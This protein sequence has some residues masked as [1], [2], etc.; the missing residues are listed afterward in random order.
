MMADVE[1][2]CRSSWLTM[3]ADLDGEWL[4]FKIKEVANDIHYNQI[5]W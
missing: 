4:L 5:K 1:R 3:L 2:F